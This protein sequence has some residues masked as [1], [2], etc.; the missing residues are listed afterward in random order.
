MNSNISGWPYDPPVVYFSLLGPIVRQL[1]PATIIPYVEL[2][3][4]LLSPNGV[5]T[6]NS[7]TRQESMS[8]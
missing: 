7:I 5:A 1:T 4:H 6:N 3:F 8:S 2:S